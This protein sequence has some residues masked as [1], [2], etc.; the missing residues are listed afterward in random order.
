MTNCDHTSVR[1]PSTIP[2]GTGSRSGLSADLRADDGS[3][4]ARANA[5]AASSSMPKY[6]ASLS[7]HLRVA[8]ARAGELS[9]LGG[10]GKTVSAMDGLTAVSIGFSDLVESGSPGRDP[11][12]E[13]GEIG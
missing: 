11:D 6:S 3:T 10:R 5:A 12:H 2:P 4:V 13:S 8:F 9:A 7:A 1:T